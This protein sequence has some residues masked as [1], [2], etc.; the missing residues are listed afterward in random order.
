MVPTQS[1]HLAEST[2]IDDRL[3]NAPAIGATA[4]VVAKKDERV[5]WARLQQTEESLE[6]ITMPVDV[7]DGDQP[8]CQE[9]LPFCLSSLSRPIEKLSDSR[10]LRFIKPPP[11]WGTVIS[12]SVTT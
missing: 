10:R 8:T 3:E 5:L 7:A 4:D 12:V 1:Y 6:G 11:R 9:C 2:E